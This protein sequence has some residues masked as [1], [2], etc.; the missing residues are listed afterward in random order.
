MLGFYG[1]FENSLS[2]LKPC[3]PSLQIQFHWRPFRTGRQPFK[4]ELSDGP[5]RRRR[6]DYWRCHH[7]RRRCLF[8]RL[9]VQLHHQAKVPL[10]FRDHHPNRRTCQPSKPVTRRQSPLF[11]STSA[12]A[13]QA[14]HQ[15]APTGTATT[16]ST[17]LLFVLFCLLLMPTRLLRTLLTSIPSNGCLTLSSR[18]FCY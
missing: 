10:W 13:A 9:R 2:Q 16:N 17:S 8:L 5:D 11:V 7:P 1:L 6:R 15:Q 4:A 3:F 12:T 18:Y 14:V